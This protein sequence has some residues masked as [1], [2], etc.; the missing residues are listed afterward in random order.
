MPMQ[1]LLK[2]TNPKEAKKYPV[3]LRLSNQVE[4]QLI[5]TLQVLIGSFDRF[6][7]T[8]PCSTNLSQN[9]KCLICPTFSSAEAQERGITPG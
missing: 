2:L 5:K 9:D 1:N 7:V 4:V 6:K 3:I 8:K